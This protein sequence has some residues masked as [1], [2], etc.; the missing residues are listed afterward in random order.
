MRKV[1]SSGVLAAGLVFGLG[2]TVDDG[3]G[4]TLRLVYS[5]DLRG[6]LHPCG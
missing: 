6:E 3:A 2:N 1:L 5:T 4:S